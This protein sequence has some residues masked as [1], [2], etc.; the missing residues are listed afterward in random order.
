[1]TDSVH[2]SIDFLVV[3]KTKSFLITYPF[4]TKALVIASLMSCHSLTFSNYAIDVL[5]LKKGAEGVLF[6][7]SQKK[8]GN[9]CV[10]IIT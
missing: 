1:M 8:K 2:S 5:G 3:N 9:H 6:S 7:H 10:F 4:N